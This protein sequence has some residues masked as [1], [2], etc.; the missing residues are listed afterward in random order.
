MFT[1]TSYVIYDKKSQNKTIRKSK[2]KKVVKNI[3]NVRERIIN[4]FKQ[5]YGID[6]KITFI[7]EDF[8]K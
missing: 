3:D 8:R 4:V 7:Y 6:V 2:A 5:R 1:I